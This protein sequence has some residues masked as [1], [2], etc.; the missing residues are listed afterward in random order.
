LLCIVERESWIIATTR[1][2]RIKAEI[3]G[4]GEAWALLGAHWI[5]ALKLFLD[6]LRLKEEK[7]ILFI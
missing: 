3:C 4:A 1:F 5:C 2:K 6:Y 7:K